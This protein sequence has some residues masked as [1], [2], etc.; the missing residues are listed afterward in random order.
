MSWFRSFPIAKRSITIALSGVSAAGM[1]G[2]ASLSTGR[3]PS[4]LDERVA[5]LEESMNALRQEVAANVTAARHE[6]EKAKTELG[7]RIETTASQVA[8]L[9]KKVEHAAVGG[10][11]VQAFGVLLAIY[12][13]V[14]SV[15]A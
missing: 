1:A 12:G 5:Q 15:F 10:F 13:A 4:T 9:T 8:D 3:A 14:T 11:K 7:G 2:S 6:L